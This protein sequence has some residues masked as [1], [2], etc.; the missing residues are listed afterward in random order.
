[1]LEGFFPFIHLPGSEMTC[2]IA[3]P[4]EKP[5]IQE[6]KSAP[7]YSFTCD[8]ARGKPPCSPGR[9]L[10]KLSEVSLSSAGEMERRPG[11]SEVR[12]ANAGPVLAAGRVASGEQG[13]PSP[14]R[15]THNTPSTL[16]GK[17]NVTLDRHT[18]LDT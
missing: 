3:I 15:S 14:G 5:P 18:L 2:W 4:L 12:V 13:Q 9:Q 10:A 7:R 8:L 17:I 6:L 1:M 11:L 16:H